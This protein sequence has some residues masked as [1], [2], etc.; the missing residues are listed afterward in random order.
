M[1]EMQIEL[2][3]RTCS[4]RGGSWVIVDPNAGSPCTGGGHDPARI[5][6]TLA[7]W[8]NLGK[9]ASAEEHALAL[10]RAKGG[11]RREFDRFAIALAVRLS[12]LPSWR[13]DSVQTENTV[14][15][16]IAK[17]GALVTS[18]MAVDK[19][20][21]LQFEIPN[22]FQSRA[23]VMYLSGGTGALRLGLRFLDALLPGHL[24]PPDAE[25]LP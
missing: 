1:A 13:N 14:T 23:E 9:P 18:R 15:E 17:G 6:L 10:S 11:E 16:V 25:P 3:G 21:T 22:A 19:G 2:H 8:K 24:I 7:E 20:E 12:R 4:C 5:V